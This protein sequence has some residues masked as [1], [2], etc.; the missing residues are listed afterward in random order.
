MGEKGQEFL[1]SKLKQ[2]MV[3]HDRGGRGPPRLRSPE[4]DWGWGEG[5][6]YQ[7]PSP[8]YPPP[9]GPQMG[10]YPS[11]APGLFGYFPNQ[12]PANPYF[13]QGQLLAPNTF[14]PHIQRGQACERALIGEEEREGDCVG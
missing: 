5:G 3:G 8:F 10:P 7:Q 14:N 11:S 13:N 6:W 9:M 2:G 12:A 1:L 4:E